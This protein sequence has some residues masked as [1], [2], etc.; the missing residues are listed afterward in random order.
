MM[1]ETLYIF[2]DEDWWMDLCMVV[3]VY[4]LGSGGGVWIL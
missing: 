2:G 3:M 4:N 1:V